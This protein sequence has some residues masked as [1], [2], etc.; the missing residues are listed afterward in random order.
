MNKKT[1]FILAFLILVVLMVIFVGKNSDFNNKIE[2]VC[3]SKCFNVEIADNDIERERGLMNRASLDKDSGMLFVFESGGKY[4]FW[5]KDTLIGLDIIWLDE[6]L[7]V[8]EISSAIPCSGEC[9]LYGGNKDS[10]YVLE[11]NSGLAESNDIKI[12]SKAIFE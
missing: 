2:K 12:G 10:K 8:V 11:I 3:F 1:L 6:N 7:E 4:P 5:M 9:E